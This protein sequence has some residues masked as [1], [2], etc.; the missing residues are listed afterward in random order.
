MDLVPAIRGVVSRLDPLAVLDG[1]VAMADVVSGTL[2]RPR[3]YAVLVG[4]F[5]GVAV[6]IAA[7]GIYGV[8]SYAV[9]RRTQEIGIRIALGATS[10]EVMGMFARDA[11]AMIGFGIA[12]GVGGAVALARY[13]QAMLFGV[14]SARHADISHGAAVVRPCGGTSRVLA[15]P[16]RNQS[17]PDC[18]APVRI[19]FRI[20]CFRGSVRG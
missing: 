16:S 17:G 5:A 20:S 9:S 10:G 14:M 19:R 1:A 6:V 18:R 4:L 12:I 15:G 11:G 2:V 13:L 3:F 8:L 7:V